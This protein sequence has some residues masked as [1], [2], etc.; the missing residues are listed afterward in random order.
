MNDTKNNASLLAKLQQYADHTQ[1]VL[2][3]VQIHLHGAPVVAVGNARQIRYDSAMAV[4]IAIVLI[5]LLLWRS[6]PRKRDLFL[7]LLTVSFGWL[8]GISVMALFRHEVSL[9]VLGISSVL[10]GIAVNYPL[11][12]LV[13]RK[14]TSSPD[15][16]CRKP[17]LPLSSAISLLS[18]PS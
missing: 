12:L 10:I 13:H 11:H 1:S 18:V 2:P 14:Y 9:I 15:R 6:L 5:L 3:D 17:S 4:L 16:P 7:I 8:M